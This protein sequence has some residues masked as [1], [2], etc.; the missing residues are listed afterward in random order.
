MSA[1]ESGDVFTIEQHGD[2]T[3]VLA[4]AALENLDPTLVGPAAEFILAPLRGREG[5]LVVI[6]LTEVDYFGS[7]F[8]QLLLKCWNLVAKREGGQMV[9]AGVSK[10]AR[11]LLHITSLD[12]IWPIY[13]SRQEAI[14]ALLA[15]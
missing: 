5:P 7:V 2:V 9:L 12:M 8:L 3:V 14:E 6:D 11:E 15:D 1:H 4:S 13:A 10:R